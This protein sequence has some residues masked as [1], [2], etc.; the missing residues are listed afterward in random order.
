MEARTEQLK[1]KVKRT[2]QKEMRYQK[3]RTYLAYIPK[4]GIDEGLKRTCE[5]VN[6]KKSAKHIKLLGRYYFEV[7]EAD[8]GGSEV[9]FEASSTKCGAH[10]KRAPIS[11]P[12][13]ASTPEAKSD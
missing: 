13:F 6:D 9:Q 10:V 2:L 7:Y 8:S 4:I 5:W 12:S 11:L 1:E 3:A